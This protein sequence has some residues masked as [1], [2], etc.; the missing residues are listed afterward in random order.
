MK[1]I[2]YQEVMTAEH[3]KKKSYFGIHLVLNPNPRKDKWYLSVGQGMGGAINIAV[4]KE[5]YILS[6]RSTWLSFKNKKNH[7]ILVENEP[8]LYN[9]YGV[10]P[11]NQQNVQT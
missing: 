2:L 3:I 5:A 4:N 1:L 6:D 9:Y 7:V 11:I 8:L 10:I